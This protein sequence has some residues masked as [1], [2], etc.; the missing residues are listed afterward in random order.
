MASNAEDPDFKTFSNYLDS[1]FVSFKKEGLQ[2]LVIDVRNNPG[3]NDPTY[4]KVFT[5]LTD[6]P[7]RENTE[8]YII[9]NKLPYSQYYK[10]N[11]SDKSNQKRELKELN[12]YLQT[13]FSVKKAGHYHQDSRFNPVYTPDT[14]RFKGNIYL[15]INE[16]VGSAASHFAS[17]VRGHSDAVIVGVETS[18]GYYGH[19]GHFPVEY[20]LPHSKITTRFS[21][22]H[23]TQDAPQKSSQPVGRGIIP[24]HQV[25]Q[26]FEDFMRNED[27]QM[28][29]V[30][31]LIESNQ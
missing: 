15:L 25:S 7:F 12:A 5:Y 24:D 9:F 21:I 1:L 2:N 8:A 6:H 4:E 19:N 28:K 11:S 26:S 16:D 18:G 13:T 30:L 3:G 23:V 14:S 22:V 17:L 31:K 20:V 29:Y 10:W 27:T